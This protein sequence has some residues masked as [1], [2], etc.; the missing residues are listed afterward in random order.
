MAPTLRCHNVLD[1]A[2]EIRNPEQATAWT[3]EQAIAYVAALARGAWQLVAE[4]I[5]F[6]TRSTSP[7]AEV[8]TELR[9]VSFQE[10]TPISSNQ[11][12]SRVD[13]TRP[14]KIV[15]F[16]EAVQGCIGERSAGAVL[17]E[18]DSTGTDRRIEW[19]SAYAPTIDPTTT[20]LAYQSVVDGLAEAQK[21][22][23]T[24]V[25]VIGISPTILSQWRNMPWSSVTIST[26]DTRQNS[27]SLP[28]CFSSC[29]PMSRGGVRSGHGPPLYTVD[30]IGRWLGEAIGYGQLGR[31]LSASATGVHVDR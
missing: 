1:L 24:N 18:T 14:H 30:Y 13:S 27:L 6:N 26:R 28:Y 19:C 31:I 3:K 17:V 12:G 11:P 23:W 8:I 20:A 22:R 4:A 16:T 5:L 21:R 29:T 7:A 2:M 9:H 10:P 25:A 15:F